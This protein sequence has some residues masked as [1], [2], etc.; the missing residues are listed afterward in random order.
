MINEFIKAFVLIF[1][2]EMGDKSQLIAMTFAT[3]YRLKTVLIGIFI[4]TAINHIIAV[5]IGVF[6]SQLIPIAI[7]QVSA[8]LFFLIFGL[9]T[10]RE[11]PEETTAQKKKISIHPI[12]M[13][14]TVFFIGELG[15]KTQLTT[16]ALASHSLSPLI[17]LSG[18]VLGMF[19]TSII[20]IL[21]GYK[22][23]KDIPEFTIKIASA[24]IFIIFGLIKLFRFINKDLLFI[25]GIPLAVIVLTSYIA[26]LIKAFR[27]KEKLTEYKTIAEKL[28]VLK[29]DINDQVE[30]TCLTEEH[31]GTCEANKC[32]IGQIK[33]II[34]SGETIDLDAQFK[35][36]FTDAE[37]IIIQEK[38]I[39]YLSLLKED[40]TFKTYN[41]IRKK[42]DQALFNQEFTFTGKEKYIEDLKKLKSK[43]S[44]KLIK[45]IIS[46]HKD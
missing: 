2:A 10:L 4:G 9:L 5:S 20:G 18:T 33:N 38:I 19:V 8:S 3:Q 37:L 36:K 24:S 21:I 27:N 26:L 31:C 28:K 34:A 39:N 32:L 15:D 7:V 45:K 25:F 12:I 23:G 11:E 35:N 29:E 43:N 30:I 17:T 16:I 22:F 41:N 1:F 42:I 14:A 6:L 40:S 46:N 44:K 13:I